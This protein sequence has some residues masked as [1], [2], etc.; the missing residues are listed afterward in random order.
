MFKA[1]RPAP[2]PA[3]AVTQTPLCQ[4][5]ALT[6]EAMDALGLRREQK[7]AVFR[8]LAALLHLGNVSVEVVLRRGV[9]Q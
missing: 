2:T 7:A 1:V 8:A 4:E 9:Q 6:D 3:Y 5:F